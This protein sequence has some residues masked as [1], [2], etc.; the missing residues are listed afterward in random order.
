MPRSRALALRPVNSVKHE[1]TWSNLS[2]NA[3]TVQNILLVKGVDNPVATTASDVHVGASVKWIYIEFN[4][5]GV[6]NSGVVQIFHWLIFKN[7]QNK[8]ITSDTDPATYNQDYRRQILKRGMEMLPEI[9]I[10]SGGT[11]Q[12]KRIFTVKL[13][14]GFLRIGQDDAINLRYKSTSTSGINF[15]GIAIYKEFY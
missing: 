7:P 14:R 10:G 9:P 6:D 11:V 13:P 15:C 12:T 3:S 1:I 8:Y 5:N 4:L 2:Q